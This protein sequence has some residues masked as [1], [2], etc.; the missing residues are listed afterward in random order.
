MVAGLVE[1][2]VT[3]VADAEQL[4]IHAAPVLD[5]ALIGLAHGGDVGGEAVG[6]D[7]VLGLD[8]DMVKQ[9][10]LHEAAI[11]LRMAGRKAFILVQIGRANARKIN[12][13][14]LFAGDELT[15]QRQRG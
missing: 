6:D 2:D 10:F 15:I 14:S 11:A 3:V 1:A 5:F 12:Q 8:G 7:G 13:T 9:I 4:D